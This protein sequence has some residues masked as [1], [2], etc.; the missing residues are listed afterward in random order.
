MNEA[1]PGVSDREG[2]VR[3]A[4]WRSDGGGFGWVRSSVV[5]RI[6]SQA[7]ACDKHSRE[8]SPLWN[9]CDHICILPGAL[10]AAWGRLGACQ[11]TGLLQVDPRPVT[12]CFSEMTLDYLNLAVRADSRGAIWLVG[13]DPVWLFKNVFIFANQ[14]KIWKCHSS[15]AEWCWTV[16]NHSYSVCPIKP[17]NAPKAL[18]QDNP[19]MRTASPAWPWQ[20]T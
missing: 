15:G 3:A 19:Q 9:L 20:I 1:A 13:M 16:S 11:S 4:G 14:W 10:G 5:Q 6:L 8:Q 17:L 7:Q 2:A 12:P 18:C